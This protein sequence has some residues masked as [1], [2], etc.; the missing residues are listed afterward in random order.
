MIDTLISLR[1]VIISQCTLY[2]NIKLYT[3][4]IYNSY[5]SIM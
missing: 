1:V 5:M 4:N 2:K 3:L